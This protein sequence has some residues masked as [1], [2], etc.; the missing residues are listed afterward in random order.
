M[1]WL[2]DT[3][4]IIH[5][6]ESAGKQVRFLIHGNHI[7]TTD[8]LGH[9]T[10]EYSLKYTASTLQVCVRAEKKAF[11]QLCQACKRTVSPEGGAV[12]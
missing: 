1:F 12:Y 8:A 4:E 2:I 5:F 11:G 10:L 7:Y 9:K 3:S 6:H